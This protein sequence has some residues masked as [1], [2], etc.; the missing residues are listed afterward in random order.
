MYSFLVKQNTAI[1]ECTFRSVKPVHVVVIQNY[2]HTGVGDNFF[3][4]FVEYEL[5]CN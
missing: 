5:I 3:W 2:M 4:H 1:A